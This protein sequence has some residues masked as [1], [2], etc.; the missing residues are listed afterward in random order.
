MLQVPQTLINYWGFVTN[1]PIKN[2]HLFPYNSG[3]QCQGIVDRHGRNG[4]EP[5]MG[6]SVLGMNGEA[7]ISYPRGPN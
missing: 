4:D 7:R 6:I 1:G 5:K 2:Y 3:H